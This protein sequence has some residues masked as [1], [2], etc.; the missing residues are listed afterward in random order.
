MTMRTLYQVNTRVW[1]RGLS[2]APRRR[3]TL[4]DLPDAE[5]DRLAGLGFD[6]LWCL[7]VWETGPIGREIA[8]TVP[9]LRREYAAV[10]PDVTDADI[11]SSCFAITRYA[12]DPSLGD[13]A[14]LQ[15]LRARLHR[16][17]MRLVLDFVPNHTARDHPWV[18]A[19]PEFYVHGSEEQLARRPHDY[20]AIGAGE[21]R[22]ILAHGRD[23]FFPGWTD[24]LQL[25]YGNPALQEAMRGE[26]LKIAEWC[27]GLRCDM[28]MLVLSNVFQMTWHLPAAP[29]WPR[30]IREVRAR[31]PGFL[32]LAEVYWDLEW[33]LQEQGFDYTYDKRLYDRLRQGYGAAVRE[34][35]MAETAFQ[36]KLA[37][38]LENHD[39]PR[40]ASAFPPDM[41]RAAAVLAFLSPGLRFVHQG[42]LEG[43]K[44]RLPV[45]LCRAPGEPVDTGLQAFYERLLACLQHAA[46]RD[47]EWRLLVPAAAW[48]GNPTW[49]AFV[50]SAWEGPGGRR[51]LVTVNYG[52]T[53]GQCYVRLPFLDRGRA[54]R[55]R[56]QMGPAAYERSA[57]ELQEKG[58]YL[59]LPAW[60][61]HVFELEPLG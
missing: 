33:T 49:K 1:L 5:L 8:R 25:N 26:L 28:A 18:A 50:A 29:F 9:E 20:C 38:F 42:Q 48:D 7:G 19:H 15:R 16:R 39:E 24:T 34:H 60:G 55:L 12:V 46:I 11:C 51:L 57:D 36:W 41:H 40:A 45:Q 23:P 56:D 59:D 35:L 22:R 2:A 14:A 31:N 21:H 6:A 13:L 37:R 53:Q 58:L 4:D 32:F 52:A 3:T 27:D 43:R 61:Y 54:V 10:L 44:A 30:A 17:G 47:G